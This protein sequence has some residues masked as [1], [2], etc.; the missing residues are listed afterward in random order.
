MTADDEEKVN[1]AKKQKERANKRQFRRSGTGEA[2]SDLNDSGAYDDDQEDSLLDVADK[3]VK[4]GDGVSDALSQRLVTE[5][6]SCK[7][8][9]RNG[10]DLLTQQ[11]VDTADALAL[12][13]QQLASCQAVLSTA[14]AVLIR[15]LG[16]KE[17]SSKK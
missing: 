1:A 14:Q 8:I 7:T 5:L 13:Q 3:R 9:T 16:S 17:A 10:N 12:V 4:L 2:G 6:Q 15:I 11:S